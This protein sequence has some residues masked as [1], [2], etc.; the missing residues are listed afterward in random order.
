M[1]DIEQISKKVENRK[2]QL[3]PLL[4][5]DKE[6]YGLWVGKEDKF[7]THKTAINITGTEI[8]SLVRRTQASIIRSRLDIHVWTPKPLENPNAVKTANQEER[9]Y[10]HGFRMADEKLVAVG[11]APLLPATGWQAI[12]PGRTAVRVLVYRDEKTG[13]IIWDFLPLHPTFLTFAFDDKGLAWYNSE[14][15]CSPESIK[16]EYGVEVV[17]DVQGKG[18]SK[19][20]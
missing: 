17:E 7:D 4:T 8:T 3:E 20:D 6:N 5:K 11:E 1:R 12:V 18:I 16:R 13:E 19:N 2:K 9:M 14:T 10:Y 15:F